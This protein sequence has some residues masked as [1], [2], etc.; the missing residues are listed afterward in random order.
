M[1]TWVERSEEAHP[2]RCVC[3]AAVGSRMKLLNL[4]LSFRSFCMYGRCCLRGRADSIG[5]L[6]SWKQATLQ[7]CVVKP[8]MAVITVALQAY[9]KYKD[10]D[11]K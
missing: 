7:F 6:R 9:G 1:T 4:P 10:G 3:R 8:L 5:L 11:F 2:V